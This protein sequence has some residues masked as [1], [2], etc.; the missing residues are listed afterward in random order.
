MSDDIDIRPVPVDKLTTF[1][2]AALVGRQA[3]LVE[4][5]EEY[6]QRAEQLAIDLKDAHRILV[7]LQTEKTNVALAQQL[8]R[9]DMVRVVCPMCKGT[10]IK[11]ADVLS[12]RVLQQGS[13]FENAGPVKTTTVIDE[14]SRC[15]DCAGQRWIVMPRFKG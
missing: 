2:E 7:F 1:G 12:G 11:P 13:A 15:V 8:A 4:L 14:R 5:I 9:G 6:T 3:R 10:G